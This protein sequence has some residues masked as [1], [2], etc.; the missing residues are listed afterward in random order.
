MTFRDAI[1]L[2][3]NGRYKMTKK[4]WDENHYITY[5]KMDD[6]D[7]FSLLIEHTKEGDK[8]FKI[9]LKSVLSLEWEIVKIRG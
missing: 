8:E 9:D 1:I 3:K 6:N 5:N 4:S 2:C 7:T